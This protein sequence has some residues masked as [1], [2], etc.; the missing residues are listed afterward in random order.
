[1]PTVTLRPNADGDLLDLAIYPSTPATHFD[2]VDEE[3]SDGDSTYVYYLDSTEQL[4]RRD[5]YNLPDGIIPDGSTINSVTVYVVVRNVVSGRGVYA[6]TIKTG[7]VVYDGTLNVPLGTAWNTYSTT[8]TTNPNTGVAW[9]ISEI[10]ALQIGIKMRGEYYPPSEVYIS[11]R[12]TQVYVVIDYTPPVVVKKPTMKIDL[13][14]HP[15]S[16]LQFKKSMKTFFG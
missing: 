12:C 10:D 11:G 8:Y 1:M 2:K 13:G 4:T 5:L 7:G 6:T 14:P 16:R 9:T 15:R 3:T